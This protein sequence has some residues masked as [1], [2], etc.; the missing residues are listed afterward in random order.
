MYVYVY[1]YMYV[2]IYIYIFV[3]MRTCCVRIYIYIYSVRC[4]AR[5]ARGQFPQN[6]LC[7]ARVKHIYIYIIYIYI[8]TVYTTVRAVYISSCVPQNF[9]LYTRM[10]VKDAWWDDG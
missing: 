4:A 9:A 3:C 7:M 8:N 10:R 6:L 1:V 2:Y 5:G